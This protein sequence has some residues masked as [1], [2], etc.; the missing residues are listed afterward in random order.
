MNLIRDELLELIQQP[1]AQDVV[2][3]EG[4]YQTRIVPRQDLDDD[5]VDRYWRLFRKYPNDFAAAV[6]RLLPKDIRFL[7][8][9]HLSNMLT[10]EQR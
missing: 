7:S 2:P 8:Y 3:V 4:T 10:Y 1:V 6:N 5:K 9:N